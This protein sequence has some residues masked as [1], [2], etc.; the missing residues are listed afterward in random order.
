MT[1]LTKKQR[2]VLDFIQASQQEEGV[3]PSYADIAKHFGYSSLTT[4]VDHIRSLQK[5]GFLSHS[6]RQ[7]RS[8]KLTAPL[9]RLRRQIAD[10]P[11][12][13]DI[14]AGWAQDREQEALGCVSIDIGSLGFKPSPNTFALKVQGDSMIGKHIVE[15]DTVILEHGLSP[16]P[17]DV[18]AALIDN[19]S[20][21]KT[22]TME[23]GQPF[24][25]SENPKYPAL[26]PV[27]ELVIQGVMITLIRKRN[28]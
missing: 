3:T 9:Q 2:A 15:G 23:E 21:L 16:Q 1:K 13:G 26:F 14:P 24:L 25:R 6:F 22:Y 10:I 17:G 8:F 27:N 19:E 7:A 28:A 5:K 12:F 11:L 4:A 20:T 18:V